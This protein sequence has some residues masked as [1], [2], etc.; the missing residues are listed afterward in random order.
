MGEISDYSKGEK[1]EKGNEMAEIGDKC[2]NFVYIQ[3]SHFL[4]SDYFYHV[5]A[6]AG[7]FL[8]PTGHYTRTKLRIRTDFYMVHCG[9]V[10]IYLSKF[11]TFF[12]I[13]I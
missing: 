6:V 4:M 2:V 10:C 1:N 5:Y 3:L 11:C 7:C 13:Q 12:E 8:K 9:I